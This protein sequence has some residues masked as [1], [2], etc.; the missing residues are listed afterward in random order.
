MSEFFSETEMNMYSR[1]IQKQ[2]VKIKSAISGQKPERRQTAL[3]KY[4]T[5]TMLTMLTF[6]GLMVL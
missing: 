2:L 1:T 6:K 3:H 5:L 4:Q